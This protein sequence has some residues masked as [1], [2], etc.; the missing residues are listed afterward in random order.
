MSNQN[1][2]ESGRR[3]NVVSPSGEVLPADADQVAELEKVGYSRE[4]PDLETQRLGQEAERNYY[5]SGGQQA[6]AGLEGFASGVSIGVSDLLLDDEQTRARARYN[7]GTRLATELIGAI[8]PAALS[9]GTGAIGTAARLTPTGALAAGSARLAKG[10]GAGM[11]TAL[12]LEGGVQGAGTALSQ[13]VLNHDPVTVESLVTGAGMGSLLSF[14]LGSLA[15]GIGGAGRKAEAHLAAK[16]AE[17][18]KAA[19]SKESAALKAFAAD[20]SE[21]AKTAKRAVQTAEKS[22]SSTELTKALKSMGSSA[23]EIKMWSAANG[24]PLTQLK[25]VFEAARAGAEVGGT[26]GA[27]AVN[28]YREALSEAGKRLGIEVK[29]PPVATD[30][31]QKLGA[32]A[33]TAALLKRVPRT[34]AEFAAMS[35]EKATTLFEGLRRALPDAGDGADHLRASLR[36]SVEGL[37][38]EG[39]IKSTQGGVD[40][41]I[42]GLHAYHQG[43]RQLAKNAEGM[44]SR[45]AKGGTFLGLIG[46]TAK[47][48]ASRKASSMAVSAGGGAALSALAYHASGLSTGLVAAELLGLRHAAIS[49]VEQLVAKIGAPVEKTLN[50]FAPAIENLRVSLD[51]KVDKSSDIRELAAK[52]ANEIHALSASI[53]DVAYVAAEPLQTAS[54]ELALKTAGQIVNG[55]QYLVK[56]APKDPGATNNFLQ[57]DWRPSESQSYELAA[58]MEAV[59]QPM[60]ALERLLGGEPDQASADALWATVPELMTRA[61]AKL[62]EMAPELQEKADFK[63]RVAL[64]TAFKTPLDGLMHPHVVAAMQSQFIPRPTGT[65]P[66]SGKRQHPAPSGRPPAVAVGSVQETRTQ[67]LMR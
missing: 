45:A 1:D 20:A 50:R 23:D 63:T 24:R 25:G 41:L 31:V 15:Q 4:T 48:A 49:H 42:D 18:A 56:K 11:K 30:A 44:S 55:F 37:L 35:E 47:L 33:D 22:L 51:G 66:A 59:M 54:P 29:V 64:S 21:M 32:L 43:A 53:N 39:G 57:S 38:A 67:S 2:V 17:S 6:L 5:S 12:A 62:V 9:G 46:K 28:A 16:H 58:T 60:V 14:G 36:S 13:A 61:A 3:V 19:L 8:A 7:P 34:P 26:E 27:R 65:G 40:G 10:L 52:R